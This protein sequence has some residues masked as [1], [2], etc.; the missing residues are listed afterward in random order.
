MCAV[1]TAIAIIGL[2]AILLIHVIDIR[3]VSEAACHHVDT[4]NILGKYT[5]CFY[6]Q[7]WD[8]EA[9]L[10]AISGFYSTLIAVLI[11]VQALIS[12]LA[13]VVVRASNRSAIE[14]EIEKEL[15]RYF[16]TVKSV[17]RVK[18]F[19]EVASKASVADQYA[20]M[21]KTIRGLQGELEEVQA[22]LY[23]LEENGNAIEVEDVAEGL[24]AEEGTKD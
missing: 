13:F 21:E 5:Y 1:A 4:S 9:Y 6:G 14:E 8:E 11:A 24:N 22:R 16:D 18:S 19:V 10:S 20:Q 23:E 3:F 12:I 7:D 15:P 2:S 17:D